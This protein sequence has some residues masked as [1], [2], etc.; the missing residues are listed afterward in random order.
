MSTFK[1]MFT[2]NSGTTNNDNSETDK[3]I[4]TPASSSTDVSSPESTKLLTNNDIN[5][6]TE[7]SSESIPIN[8]SNISSETQPTLTDPIPP[9]LTSDVDALDDNVTDMPSPSSSY[10]ED[11]DVPTTT[12]PITQTETEPLKS[13]ELYEAPNLYNTQTTTRKRSLKRRRTRR[14]K[15]SS[16][17]KLMCTHK[18]VVC[19]KKKKRK[20]SKSKKSKSKSKSKSKRYR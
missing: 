19:K 1:D 15:L 5:K 10:E 14:N 8:D 17:C 18:M 6:P 11:D 16:K 12:Q 7:Q 13:N 3:P 9:D 20:L 4:T 2:A